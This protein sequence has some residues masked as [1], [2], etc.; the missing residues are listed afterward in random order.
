MIALNA[1]SPICPVIVKIILANSIPVTDT[2]S[3]HKHAKAKD[4]TAPKNHPPIEP[5]HV[6]L[7]ETRGFNLCLPK[8]LPHKYAAVSHILARHSQQ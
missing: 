3:I 2:L 8:N 6:F 7:G 4:R 5:S 1:K